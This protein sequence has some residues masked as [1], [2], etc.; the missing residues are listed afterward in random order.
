MKLNFYQLIA[1]KCLICSGDKKKFSYL[2]IVWNIL[3]PLR[4]V[5][6]FK[7]NWSIAEYEHGTGD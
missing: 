3:T 7:G 6:K 1:I 5:D 4:E 2:Y